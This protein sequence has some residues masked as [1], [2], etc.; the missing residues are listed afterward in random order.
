MDTT[1]KVMSIATNGIMSVKWLNSEAR[2]RVH[3]RYR[4]RLV[5]LLGLAPEPVPCPPGEEYAL[6]T[7]EMCRVLRERREVAS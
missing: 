3:A 7:G 1:I 2:R 6:T 4:G 5:K